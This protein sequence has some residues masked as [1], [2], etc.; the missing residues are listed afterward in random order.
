MPRHSGPTIGLALGGGGAR[1]LAHIPMLEA[2]DE[3]GIR[4]KI[5]AGTSIGAVFGA[6]YAAG[7]RAAEIRAHTEEVLGQRFDLVRELFRARAP[8]I[9]RVLG[10]FNTRSAFLEPAAL[11]D[12]VLPSRFPTEFAALRTP[13]EI[14][15][16]DF[17]AQEARVFTSGP[18]R[19]AIAASMALPVVFQP[20]AVDGRALVDGG[21]TNPLPFDLLDGK[22]EV[23]VAIDVT[24]APLPAAGRALPS[25]SEVLFGSAF[26][27]ERALIREKLRSR[28][29]DILIDAGM[30]RF[31][32]LDFLRAGEI[33]AAALPAKE[34]L[35]R[36][37]A[38]LI[39]AETLEALPA[40]GH[41]SIASGSEAGPEAAKGPPPG[42]P[43]ARRKPRRRLFRR[44][45]KGA[46][47]GPDGSAV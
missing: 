14:V 22:A 28:R 7:M 2:F 15:A 10:L 33:L 20:V 26:L 16:T 3:L 9:G 35:K 13:L 24:G 46:D 11:L 42:A 1:G 29:P 17:Y 39:E 47:D 31:Q 40:P 21:L 43:S 8:A 32:V 27:F 6:A 37:L 30:S 45:R 19:P 38:R 41:A 36:Q 25:A 34:L 4:P 5:I 18:L 12:L 23:V 44:G